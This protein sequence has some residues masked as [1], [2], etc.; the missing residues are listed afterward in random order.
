M[1]WSQIIPELSR[2]LE[3]AIITY[4]VLLQQL[5]HVILNQNII[6]KGTR[7]REHDLILH[8]DIAVNS[9]GVTFF[10]RIAFWKTL[11]TLS[12]TETLVLENDIFNS[13]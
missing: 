11:F 1:T 6:A 3:S 7:A 5:L 10:L 9:D 2:K 4:R 12:S 13:G 8:H